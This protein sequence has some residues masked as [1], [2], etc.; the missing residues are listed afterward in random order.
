MTLAQWTLG[1]DALVSTKEK[2]MPA[3]PLP[4]NEAQRLEALRALHLLDT[5]PEERFD[6]ITRLAA[7]ILNVPMACVVLV[8]ENRQ[9]LKSRYGLDLIETN[10][11]NSFC[12]YT[13]LES[14]QMVVPDA[15]MDDRFKDNPHVTGKPN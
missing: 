15:K 3:A 12:P 7:R 10:R 6:R 11:D 9:F 8:D 14:K 1:C 13:I 4:A 2:E 5:P